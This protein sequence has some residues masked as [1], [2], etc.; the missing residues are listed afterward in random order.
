MLNFNYK[1]VINFQGVT[2]DIL[3][4]HMIVL[5]FILVKIQYDSQLMINAFTPI[6]Y[7]SACYHDHWRLRSI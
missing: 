6:C 2:E 5:V 3:A 7:T 1:I 4:V